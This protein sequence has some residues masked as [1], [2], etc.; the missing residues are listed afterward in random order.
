MPKIETAPAALERGQGPDHRS[1]GEG[2]TTQIVAP[3]Q[4]KNTHGGARVDDAK[5]GLIRDLAFES[6]G[7]AVHYGDVARKLLEI[8]DDA[9]A[10]YAV[11]QLR[12]AVVTACQCARELRPS[13]RR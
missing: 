5:S 3:A 2:N 6:I 11:G 10:L 8:N 13:V 1:S 7:I 12:L 4:A 9:G